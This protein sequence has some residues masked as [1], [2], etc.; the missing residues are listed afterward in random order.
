MKTYRIDRSNGET[1]IASSFREAMTITREMLGSARIY[2][3]AEYQTDRPS[4]E[5]DK[6]RE[7][8]TALDIWTSRADAQIQSGTPAPVVI[9]W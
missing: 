5:A 1:S 3:G 4:I 7:T 9:S 8:C 6:D 2:R